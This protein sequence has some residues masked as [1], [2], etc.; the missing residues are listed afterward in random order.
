MTYESLCQLFH[1][2]PMSLFRVITQQDPN[3][4]SADQK[5]SEQIAQLKAAVKDR[6]E[7]IADKDKMIKKLQKQNADKDKTL[8]SIY[9][10]II[11]A[12]LVLQ[13]SSDGINVCLSVFKKII[14]M[15]ES[16]QLFSLDDVSYIEEKIRA[17]SEKVRIQ[18]EQAKEKERKQKILDNP[19]TPS[20]KQSQYT[21]QRSDQSTWGQP[22]R[23]EGHE[24]S[25]H[26]IPSDRTEKHKKEMCDSCGSKNL[27]STKSGQSVSINLKVE[28]EVVNN[29]GYKGECKECG[30]KYNTLKNIPDTLSNTML[31]K[32]LAGMATVMRWN[33]CSISTI[34]STL[35]CMVPYITDN[36]VTSALDSIGDGLEPQRKEI[37]EKNLESKTIHMDET[38]MPLAAILGWIWVLVGDFGT[39]FIIT[40]SRTKIFLDV[41]FAK[42]IHIPLVCDGYSPYKLFKIRQRCWAHVIRYSEAAVCDIHTALMCHRL[43]KLY[44]FAKQIQVIDPNMIPQLEWMVNDLIAQTLELAAEYKALD[45]KFGKHLENAAAELYTFVTHYG[46]ESTNNRAERALRRFV[47]FR[48]VCQRVVGDKSRERLANIFTCLTTWDQQGLDVYETLLKTLR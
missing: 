29:V 34:T 39:Q 1:I 27:T 24:G 26:H 25:S 46:M 11:T 17:K 12:L 22:G 3:P 7:T 35:R 42:Y 5:K 15:I 20:S 4:K 36:M 44:E 9:K 37:E 33:G 41:A 30:E 16:K 31:G 8:K 28:S 14:K 18:T 13:V 38:S 32:K 45:I 19:S 21:R 23:E 2:K 6:D 48:K 47:L 43:K 10:M 40:P